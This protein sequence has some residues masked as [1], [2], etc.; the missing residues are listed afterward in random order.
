[1]NQSETLIGET[2]L[3]FP[4]NSKTETGFTERKAFGFENNRTQSMSIINTHLKT[5]EE[6]EA[7]FLSEMNAKKSMLKDHNDMFD[8]YGRVNKDKDVNSN[9][10]SPKSIL[11]GYMEENY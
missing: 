8:T 2:T 9:T 3:F 7:E 6:I 11:S 10:Y 4:E 1:M 5:L